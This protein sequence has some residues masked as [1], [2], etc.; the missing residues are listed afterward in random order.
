[1]ADTSANTN[2]DAPANNAEP[3]ENPGN[4]PAAD[5]PP[6]EEENRQP[7]APQTPQGGTPSAPLPGGDTE[8]VTSPLHTGGS[9]GSSGN[10]D[11][12][13]R[14]PNTASLQP[15]QQGQNTQTPQQSPNE[16]APNPVA[17]TW[18]DTHRDNGSF[19][20]NSGYGT[21]ARTEVTGFSQS[22]GSGSSTSSSPPVEITSLTGDKFSAAASKQ[23]GN[24][25]T[26]VITV[27]SFETKNV[28][29]TEIQRPEPPPPPPPK[30]TMED[31]EPPV[32]PGVELL[33]DS[34]LYQNDLV[35]NQGIL[36]LSNIEPT[37]KVTYSTDGSLWTETFTPVYGDN[38]VLVQQT[39]LNL[40]VSQPTTFTFNYDNKIT[41]TIIEEVRD[42]YGTKRGL[43]E[44]GAITDDANLTLNGLVDPDRLVSLRV[45]DGKTFIGTPQIDG[46][47]WKFTTPSFE[48]GDHVLTVEATD[49][50]GNVAISDPFKV[51]VL[52][53]SYAIKAVSGSA[54]EGAL[55]AESSGSF[56]YQVTR[57]GPDIDLAE[58]ILYHIT[59]DTASFIKQSEFSLSNERV[60]LTGTV[61]FKAG[62]TKAQIILDLEGDNDVGQDVGFQVGLF[63]LPMGSINKGSANGTLFND[64]AWITVT[65]NTPTVAGDDYLYTF[66]VNRTTG[67][68]GVNHAVNYTISG[69]GELPLQTPGD[70]LVGDLSG[71]VTF[72]GSET[73]KEVT[74]KVPVTTTV[75]S[76]YTFAIQLT[77]VSEE[78]NL[79]LINDTATT[80]MIANAVH[81]GI[82]AVDDYGQEGTPGSTGG[83]PLTFLVT[84]SGHLD[85]TTTVPWSIQG[86]G[87]HPILNSDFAS[88][89]GTVTFNPGET[90]KT[91]SLTPV[92]NGILTT[93]RT[94]QVELASADHVLLTHTTASG[95][96]VEDECALGLDP[97]NATSIIEGDSGQKV[98]QFTVL[99][100]GFAGQPATVEWRLQPG[101]NNPVDLDDVLADQD[102]LG[103]NDGLPSGTLTLATGESKG[104]ASFNISPDV[105]Y[106]L[107]EGFSI[108]L[109]NP[110]LGSSLLAGRVELIGVITSDDSLLQI[111]GSRAGTY[112]DSQFVEDGTPGTSDAIALLESHTNSQK[113]VEITVQRVGSVTGSD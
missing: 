83:V 89:T 29:G 19:N 101:K 65:A 35:S 99:R 54:L 9:P 25:E 104:T 43:L 52:T 93:N 69:S 108:T 5:A 111:S 81:V 96:I 6:Q 78:S 88:L 95:T 15:S 46:A 16:P 82:A 61:H 106:E 31:V 50:A 41:P 20:L 79:T 18:T 45:L 75:A 27:N 74:L 67:T 66:T 4:Q 10:S 70:M 58:D 26:T 51:T 30:P 8:G 28:V 23:G 98:M 77:P 59:D 55:N 56:T 57:I 107:D 109:T 47:N 73:S 11:G 37:A 36:K 39:D 13:A 90:E 38:T 32:P 60:P 113:Y 64:D 87:E 84:R 97:N 80:T 68:N 33:V 112:Q 1:M 21:V 72:S 48:D 7:M 86:T 24:T 49:L 110:S 44:N 42:D 40:N 92:A 85:Q 22:N 76:G 100:E 71:T 34:G 17:S 94:F 91:L 105:A 53:P 2:N 103:D 12:T 102:L 3:N 14:Q 62:E 63:N